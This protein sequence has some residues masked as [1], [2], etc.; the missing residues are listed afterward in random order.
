MPSSGLDRLHH[1]HERIALIRDLLGNTSYSEAVA[2]KLRWPAFERH[3]EVISEASRKV[4]AE[5]KAEHASIQWSRIAAIGNLLRHAYTQINS[6]ILWT[7]YEHDLGSL[8]A[9]IEAMIAEHRSD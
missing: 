5:W 2:D 9:A 7:I 8:N 1:I 3:L 6:E 4:P